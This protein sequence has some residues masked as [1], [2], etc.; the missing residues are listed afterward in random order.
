MEDR[1]H[2]S[3]DDSQRAHLPGVFSGLLLGLQSRST[4]GL[5]TDPRVAAESGCVNVS[6]SEGGIPTVRRSSDTPQ[7]LL[8]LNQDKKVKFGSFPQNVNLGTIQKALFK[9]FVPT[10]LLYKIKKN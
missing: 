10:F 4:L 7:F 2:Q 1:L 5:P 3:H 6:C 9:S 8:L